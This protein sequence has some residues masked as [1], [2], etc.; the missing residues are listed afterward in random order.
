MLKELVMIC[1]V[2]VVFVVTHIYCMAVVSQYRM[3]NVSCSI[4]YCGS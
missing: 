2:T 1:L 4:K 3:W